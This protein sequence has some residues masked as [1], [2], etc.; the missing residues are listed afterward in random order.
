[1]NSSGPGLHPYTQNIQ[2]KTYQ[3]TYQKTKTKTYQVIAITDGFG[4][5]FFL[6]F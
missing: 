3:K 6:L 1:M 4:F 2:E 5:G